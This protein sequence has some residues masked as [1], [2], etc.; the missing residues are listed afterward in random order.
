VIQVYWPGLKDAKRKVLFSR[1][2]DMDFGKMHNKEEEK[3]EEPFRFTLDKKIGTLYVTGIEVGEDPGTDVVYIGFF[4]MIL[5]VFV[6]FYFY[7]QRIWRG[8]NRK[9]SKMELVIA[10]MATRNKYQFERKFERL[11]S[12]LL[13]SLAEELKIDKNKMKIENSKQEG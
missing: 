12:G 10:G 8:V 9:G 5:G 13:L 2:A 1:F 11:V 6:G 7:H 3:K 4:F